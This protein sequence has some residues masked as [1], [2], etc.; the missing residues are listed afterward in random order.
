M[1]PEMWRMLLFNT[2]QKPPHVPAY[3]SS[4][5]LELEMALQTVLIS[6]NESK[7]ETTDDTIN[8]HQ[9]SKVSMDGH[10]LL[11]PVLA[12]TSK[13]EGSTDALT[14]SVKIL[15]KELKKN[16]NFNST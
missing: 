9:P 13:P 11:L 3:E 15:N 4:S 6:S 12:Q 7:N 16:L 10:Q 1:T 5:K 8:E 14:Q 2:H